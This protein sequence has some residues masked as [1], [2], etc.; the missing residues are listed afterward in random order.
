M[1]PALERSGKKM[2][3]EKARMVAVAVVGGARAS[4][5]LARPRQMSDRERRER[6]GCRHPDQARKTIQLG[7]KY[8]RHGELFFQSDYYG[9]SVT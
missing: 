3:V 1:M 4:G 9:K 2:T 7:K 5:R 6:R 8:S